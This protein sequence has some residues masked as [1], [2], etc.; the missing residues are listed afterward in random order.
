MSDLSATKRKLL[1]AVVQVREYGYEP[2]LAYTPRELVQATLPHRN[3][4]DIPRWMRKN[5]NYTLVIQPGWNTKEDKS[6]GYPYGSIPRLLLFWMTTEALR[7]NS[8]RLE[9]GDHLASFMRKLD[10]D[11]STGGGKRSHAARLKDQMQRL[12]RATISFEYATENQQ[13]W[14]NMQITS[15]GMMWWNPN[16]AEQPTLWNSWI[17]LSDEFFKAI[18]EHP[19]PVDMNVLQALRKS[20]LA[21]D[22]YAWLCY[23]THLVTTKGKAQRVP[24][25]GLMGQLGAHYS[26]VQ[27]FRKYALEALKKIEQFYPELSIDIVDGALEIKPSASMIKSKIDKT[28]RQTS[29]SQPLL[30]PSPSPTTQQDTYPDTTLVLSAKTIEQ[31]K[32][33]LLEAHSRLDLYGIEAEFR[34]YAAQKG[35]PKNP[36]RAFLGFVRRKIKAQA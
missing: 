24:W 19:F 11:P 27:D 7:T 13:S 3:P 36:Q 26:D 18:T 20:P 16:L 5:G 1:D 29:K 10:L 35:I 6:Y 33:L 28:P 21:L 30:L 15:K 8:P 2:E 17:E 32:A 12:F 4:G 31:A 34:E 23:R 9:L 25:R 22:L 14:L